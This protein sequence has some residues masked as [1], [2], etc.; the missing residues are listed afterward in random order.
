MATMT[1]YAPGRFS[2]VDLATPDPEAAK[3]FYGGLFGWEFEDL[4]AGP[5]V[6]TMCKLG[7][8]RVCALFRQPP[9]PPGA[10]AAWKSYVTV[11]S[12]DESAAKAEAL[13]GAVGMAPMDVLEAGRMAVLRDPQGAV[14]AIW[15]PRQHIGAALVNEHGTFCWNEL[16]TTDCGAAEAFYTALF[17]WDA[18]IETQPSGCAYTCFFNAEGPNAGMMAIQPEWSEVPPNWAVY[19]A[20]A[21]CD[22]SLAR[23][24]ELGAT[25]L[26]PATDIPNVGRFAVLR[27]PQGAVFC[28]LRLDRPV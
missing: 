8:Q 21:D 20:V 27:D 23:S 15:E 28:I 22:G 4:P 25:V 11:T 6:Y 7:G 1:A 10:R 17:G 13:G 5:G 2:W 24:V 3:R 26:L 9:E 16:A 19:F 12:A 14:F 18:V